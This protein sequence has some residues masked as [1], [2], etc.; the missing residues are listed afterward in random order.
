MNI[1]NHGRVLGL[2]SQLQDSLNK[3]PEGFERLLD[4]IEEVI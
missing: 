1:M 2:L 4:K 3:D